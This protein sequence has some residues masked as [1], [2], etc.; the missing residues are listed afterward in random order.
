MLVGI[1]F[2]PL[3]GKIRRALAFFIRMQYTGAPSCAKGI[4]AAFRGVYDTTCE[5]VSRSTLLRHLPTG[6]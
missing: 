5:Q 6:R 3:S 4:G 2:T 1:Y